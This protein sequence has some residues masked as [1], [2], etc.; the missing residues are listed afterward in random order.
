MKITLKFFL[1]VR[2]STSLK[3]KILVTF[4][5]QMTGTITFLVKQGF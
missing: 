4:D 5:Y 2:N 1:D 3:D